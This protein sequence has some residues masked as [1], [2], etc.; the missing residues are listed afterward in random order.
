ML[1]I[2]NAIVIGGGAVIAVT[3][4]DLDA[5]ALIIE[6]AAQATRIDRALFGLSVLGGITMSLYF[7][8]SNTKYR[9]SPWSGIS[10]NGAT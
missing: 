10:E 9:L 8:Y 2:G 6:F 1:R 5:L 3:C 4:I 7:Y